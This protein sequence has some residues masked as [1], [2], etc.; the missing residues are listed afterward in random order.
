MWDVIKNSRAVDYDDSLQ[1]GKYVVVVYPGEFIEH[2]VV[3]IIFKSQDLYLKYP[4]LKFTGEWDATT[5][6]KQGIVRYKLFYT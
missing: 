3:C 1:K 6:Q 2:D 4:T 5:L